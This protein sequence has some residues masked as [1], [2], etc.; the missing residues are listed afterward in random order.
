[1]NWIRLPR[2][3]L[4]GAVLATAAGYAFALVLVHLF[5]QRHGMRV[6]PAVWFVTALPVLVGC[7]AWIGGLGLLTVIVLALWTNVLFTNDERLQVE[8]AIRG[9]IARARN[10]V[11][12][13]ID[14]YRNRSIP[15]VPG[16]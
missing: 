15:S 9:Y 12:R 1:L 7:G 14:G 8:E 6:P 13:L 2:L 3:G 5:N 11:V 10:I 16:G 4:L